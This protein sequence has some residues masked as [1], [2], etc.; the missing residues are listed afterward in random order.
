MER[1]G[2]EQLKK[3]NEEKDT[4]RYKSRKGRQKKRERRFPLPKGRLRQAERVR[5]LSVKGL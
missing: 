2:L 4:V 3:E 5:A 1:V